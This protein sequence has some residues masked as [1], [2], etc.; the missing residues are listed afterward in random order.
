MERGVAAS[1]GAETLGYSHRA[2]NTIEFSL[3]PSSYEFVLSRDGGLASSQSACAPPPNVAG[4]MGGGDVN[5]WQTHAV[6]NT[7]ML[8]QVESDTPLSILLL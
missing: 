1:L 8:E 4:R 2:E 7:P 5:C 6:Y 3:N